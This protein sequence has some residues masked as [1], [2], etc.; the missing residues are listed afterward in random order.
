MLATN[1]MRH[2]YIL[3]GILCIAAFLR[4]WHIESVPPSISWDEAAFGYNAWSVLKTG[5]D[6]YG[7][8]YPLLFES[9][10]EYKLPGMVYTVAL[11]EALFGLNEFGIRF[12]SA[13]FGTLTVLVLY[14][15]TKEY[16]KKQSAV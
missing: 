7:K 1:N 4:L 14:L 3:I 8:T 6:E 12:P 13:L 15:L 10:G 16:I 11:S 9:F 5:K 2:R